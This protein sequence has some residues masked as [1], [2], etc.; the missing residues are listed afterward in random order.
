MN[1]ERPPTSEKRKRQPRGVPNCVYFA[2]GFTAG[3]VLAEATA[4]WLGY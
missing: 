2:I 1:K 3:M 4:R